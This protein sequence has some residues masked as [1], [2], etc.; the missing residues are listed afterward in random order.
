MIV[1]ARCEEADRSVLSL[2][3]ASKI[4]T[5]LNQQ[6]LAPPKLF[7]IWSVANAPDALEDFSA[8]NKQRFIRSW[9]RGSYTYGVRTALNLPD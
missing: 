7:S 3:S 1:R 9:S 2:N 4:L 8:S 5:T 6:L